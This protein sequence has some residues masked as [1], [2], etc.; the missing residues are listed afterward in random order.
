MTNLI[1][2]NTL[3]D[4]LGFHQRWAASGAVAQIRDQLRHRIRIR[5]GRSPRAVTAILDSQSVKAA[6]TVFRASR[7]FDSR[8]LLLA[9]MVTDAGLRDGPAAR[10]LLFRLRL[11][12]PQLTIASADSAYAELH[13]G[14][15]A[16]TYLKL[17]LKTVSKPQGVKG[18]QVIPRRWR[19][20]RTIGW[21]MHSRRLARDYER[22]IQH[23]ES[24]INWSTITLMTRRLTR[25][26]STKRQSHTPSTL[27]SE[28]AA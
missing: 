9:V 4:H 25:K 28:L 7:G 20:E 22:L 3:A 15:W 21:I 19:V 10:D 16:K 23:S 26:P 13:L 27:W 1:P 12:N 17:T 5:T 8:G 24:L 14:T 6:E 18:F 11:T 2:Q